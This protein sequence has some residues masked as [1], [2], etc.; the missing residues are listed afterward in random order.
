MKTKEQILSQLYISP[1]DLK[2]LI[3]ELGIHNCQQI[4]K[5]IREEMENKNIF[6]PNSKPILAQT[7]LV[8]KIL[9]I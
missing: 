1:K 8:I 9:G 2:I 6:V 4:I 3:P 7:K 5:S